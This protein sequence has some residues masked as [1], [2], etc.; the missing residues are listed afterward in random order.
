MKKKIFVYLAWSCFFISTTNA[1]TPDSRFVAELSSIFIDYQGPVTQDYF[2]FNTFNPGIKLGAQGYANR[3]FNIS[4]NSAF[5][6]EANYPIDEVTSNPTSLIDVSAMLHFK[7]NNGSLI[8]EDF[9]VAPYLA[10]GFGLNSASN[11]LRYYVPAAF[12]LRFRVTKNFSINLESVY[13]IAV[14][15]EAQHLAH[16]GG[17][18]FN[19]PSNSKPEETKPPKSNNKK[20]SGKTGP[21]A[22]LDDSDNDGIPDVDDRC[23]NEKGLV[24]YFGCP[25]PKIEEDANSDVAVSGNPETPQEE[26]IPL[27][28][29]SDPMV[30]TMPMEE[31]E[32]EPFD[33][34]TPSMEDQ[35]FLAE[36]MSMIHFLEGSD[37]IDP[38]SYSVLDRIASLLNKYPA[39]TLRVSG[40]TDNSGNDR[41]N[42]LLSVNR[43]F[44]VKR[45]LA[46]SGGVTLSRI[47][48]DGY[49]EDNPIADNSTAEGRKLNRRVEFMLVR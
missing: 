44:S 49:G 36:A 9:F 39:H 29:E 48:S 17:F 43:A 15:G 12:G 14:D 25:N 6:P 22:E 33:S 24:L 21:I 7:T 23:P 13:K 31:E 27:P 10:A 3:F 19:L 34:S 4:L 8:R 16:S 45:Y 47:K 41:L 35:Q 46:Y 2:M 1:Q 20:P 30:T 26:P 18:V 28:T 32:P 11:N 5:I 40:Y 37:E 42:K 38:K